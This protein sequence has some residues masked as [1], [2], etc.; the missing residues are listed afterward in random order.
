[1]SSRDVKAVALVNLQNL[2]G[3]LHKTKPVKFLAR[4]GGGW[5]LRAIGGQWLLRKK[6]P[7]S[8]RC[9]ASFAVVHAPVSGP[10]PMHI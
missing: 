7:V 9:V 10:E 4:M 1:M 6:E 3:C 2:Y 8:F 5:E